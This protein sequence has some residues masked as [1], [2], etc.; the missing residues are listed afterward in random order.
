LNDVSED[1]FAVLSIAAE[2]RRE[3]NQQRALG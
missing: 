2:H 1:L 3:A